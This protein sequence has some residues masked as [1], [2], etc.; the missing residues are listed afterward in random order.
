MLNFIKKTINNTIINP[1]KESARKDY[2]KRL[3]AH[4]AETKLANELWK[5]LFEGPEGKARLIKTLDVVT[6]PQVLGNHINK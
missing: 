1:L 6:T 2:E 4:D 5:A 3:A